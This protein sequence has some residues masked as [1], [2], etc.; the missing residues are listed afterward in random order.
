MKT[1]E[2]VVNQGTSIARNV[3]AGKSSSRW[4]IRFRDVQI[5]RIF[6]SGNWKIRLSAGPSLYMTSSLD[7][8]QLPRIT[9]NQGLE[10]LD[11]KVLRGAVVHN[12]P[13]L[14]LDFCRD[15]RNVCG[16]FLRYR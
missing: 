15:L 16:D 10:S 14:L 2:T 9:N 3:A 7:F 13:F 11:G 8:V 5:V 6:A 1:S 4:K 12:V